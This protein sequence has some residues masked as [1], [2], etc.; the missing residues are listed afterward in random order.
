MV[1]PFPLLAHG[2][3]VESASVAQQQQHQL[4]VLPDEVH[5]LLAGRN[6]AVGVMYLD[7]H[8]CLA[9]F[10]VFHRDGIIQIGI[11]QLLLLAFQ[12]E[13]PLAL[14]REQRLVLLLASVQLHPAELAHLLN[15]LLGELHLRLPDALNL[16]LDSL[17]RDIR[18]VAVCPTSVSPEAEEVAVDTT[19]AP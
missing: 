3:A 17:H 12:L 16:C 9:Q 1:E 18:Q 6:E 7:Q 8:R 11:D 5:V 10:E 13:Q 14:V 15:R 2:L 19:F 4:E